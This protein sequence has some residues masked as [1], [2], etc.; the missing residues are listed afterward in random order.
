[1]CIRPVM[2][3]K[4]ENSSPP[5]NI[6]LSLVELNSGTVR[7]HQRQVDEWTDPGSLLKQE[8][9]NSAGHSG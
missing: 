5:K 3:T 6:G 4:N 2:R 7:M 8:V 1:M 9:D